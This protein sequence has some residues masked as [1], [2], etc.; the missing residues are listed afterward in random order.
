MSEYIIASTENL[1][2]VRNKLFDMYDEFD[3]L[4]S[5]LEHKAKKTYNDQQLIEFNKQLLIINKFANIVL[6]YEDISSRHIE[7][8]KK[9]KLQNNQLDK[10]LNYIEKLGGDITLIKYI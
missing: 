2:I 4:F 3:N 5:D 1:N 10:A 7:Q 6:M 8:L 9:I